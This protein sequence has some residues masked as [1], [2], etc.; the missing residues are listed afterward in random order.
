MLKRLFVLAPFLAAILCPGGPADASDPIWF[1][2]VES[3][4]GEVTF[5]YPSFHLRDGRG[6]R[7]AMSMLDGVGRLVLEADVAKAREHPERLTP[8]IIGS[9]PR[10]LGALFTPAEIKGIHARA[11]CNGVGSYTD[12]LRL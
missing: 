11:D 4:A 2:R 5:F 9:R 1:Y 3:P 8:Y 12:S 7:P 6:N 10:D